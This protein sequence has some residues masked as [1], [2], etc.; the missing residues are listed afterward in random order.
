VTGNGD[1][2]P[3]V[4]PLP[5]RLAVLA[6]MAQAHVAGPDAT[7]AIDRAQIYPGRW[8][9]VRSHLGVRVRFVRVGRYEVEAAG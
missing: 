1:A 3:V 4:R 7:D 8:I 6:W 5:N 9:P 2:A